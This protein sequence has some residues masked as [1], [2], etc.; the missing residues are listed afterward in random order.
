MKRKL[1][2]QKSNPAKIRINELLVDL[3][4]RYRDSF[5]QQQW[6][7]ET[8]RWYN[9]VYCLL[10]AVEGRFG[11]GTYADSAVRVLIELNLLDIPTLAKADETT[12]LHLGMVLERTDFSREQTTQLVNTLCELAKCLDEKY[13]GKVQLLLRSVGME[14]VNRVIGALP[15]EKLLDKQNASLVVT[16][17][18]QNVLDLPVLVPSHGLQALLAETG[19]EAEEVLAV[20]DELNINIARL[21][22][23]LNQWVG[24]YPPKKRVGEQ[25]EVT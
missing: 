13:Q 5:D 25:P 19:A 16:H 7:W 17:W 21:D 3:F 20:A 15:L 8:Q 24:A 18:L 6:P 1:A 12:R 22:E 4:D 23:I 11:L 10:S 2:T 14:M 9:L